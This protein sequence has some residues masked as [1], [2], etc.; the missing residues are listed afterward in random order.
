[1]KLETG[2]HNLF[3]T[4]KGLKKSVQNT[5]FTV[6]VNIFF[7]MFTISLPV[8]DYLGDSWEQL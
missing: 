8:C 1:M 5:L 3:E 7:L 4:H 2:L 6:F